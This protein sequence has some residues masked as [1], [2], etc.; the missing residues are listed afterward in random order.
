MKPFN[1]NVKAKAMVKANEAE[2]SDTDH[3]EHILGKHWVS[4]LDL[5]CIWKL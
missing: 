1:S 5:I 2:T 3:L 4:E